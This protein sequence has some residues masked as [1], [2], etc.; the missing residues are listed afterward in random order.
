MYFA[1]PAQCNLEE[2][3]LHSHICIFTYREPCVVSGDSPW[4]AHV[5]ES[6][7]YSLPVAARAVLPLPSLPEPVRKPRLKE[8]CSRTQSRKLQEEE[9]TPGFL[10][11][12]TK[13]WDG[14]CCGILFSDERSLQ[15]KLRATEH[16]LGSQGQPG[17]C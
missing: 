11:Y 13:G 3:H 6:N 1:L 2:L 10:C 15:S 9:V 5:L 16:H 17:N 14:G 7:S 8:V 12:G 4:A